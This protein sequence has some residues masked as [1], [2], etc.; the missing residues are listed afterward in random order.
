VS[1]RAERGSRLWPGWRTIRRWDRLRLPEP[2]RLGWR[3]HR[4]L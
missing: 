4:A 3:W 2:A 1:A